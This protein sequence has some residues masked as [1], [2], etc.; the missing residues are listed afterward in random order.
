MIDPNVVRRWTSPDRVATTLALG[1]LGFGTVFGSLP[2][3]TS[4][5]LGMDTATARRVT[6]LT[7]MTAAR[8]AALALGALGALRRG[9]D[10]APWLVAG[11]ACDAVDALVHVDAVRRG[12][13]SRRAGVLVVPVAVGATGAGVVTALRL[14]RR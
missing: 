3:A 12:R 2:V 10:P 8:D 4:R 1:R 7:R 13:L 9:A 14:R 11:A 6:W 5:L